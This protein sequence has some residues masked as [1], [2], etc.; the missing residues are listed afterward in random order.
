MS[1]EPSCKSS[2]VYNFHGGFSGEDKLLF[3]SV[4]EEDL[5]KICSYLET[6]PQK[7][8]GARCEVFDTREGK[9]DADPHHSISRASARSSEMAIYRFWLSTDDPH[10]PH[11]I[12][13]LV[14]HTWMVP[15]PWEVEL[16][17]WDGKKIKKIHEMIS[18]SFM[19]E[20][21]AIAVDDIVFGRKLLEE[22]ELKFIDDWCR[23]QKEQMPKNFASVINFAGFGS[24]PNKVVVPFCASFS[25][26]LLQT[27]G[28]ANY[29]KMYMALKEVNS[30]EENVKQIERVY[31]QSEGELLADWRQ[32]LGL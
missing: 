18:T 23:E 25:K 29:K 4:Q 1:G 27:F 12:T 20:G 16:D 21:L 31:R 17:T 9:Q 26:Y 14:A 11:E 7:L 6:A 13:H 19:Q 2:M 28:L 22:G 8:S 30:P 32:S 15:Y 24:L 10:F 5:V 3:E